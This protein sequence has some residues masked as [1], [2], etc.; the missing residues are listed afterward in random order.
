MDIEIRGDRKT[1]KCKLYKQQCYDLEKQQMTSTQ[2]KNKRRDNEKKQVLQAKVNKI[3]VKVNG[4]EIERVAK[5][6]YLGQQL[7][8]D[9]NVTISIVDNIRNA[10]R[11]QNYL[12]TILKREGAN[13]IYT[14]HFYLTMV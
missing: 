11:K 7:S 2:M 8:E 9:D 3:I 5:F 10:N 14:E 13:V 6:K 1:L 12:A 4:K